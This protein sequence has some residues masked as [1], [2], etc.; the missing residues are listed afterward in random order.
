[1]LPVVWEHPA[2]GVAHDAAHDGNEHTELEVGDQ[3]DLA[4]EDGGDHDGAHDRDGVDAVLLLRLLLPPSLLLLG[5]QFGVG[6]HEDGLP[7][8]GSHVGAEPGGGL[9][10]GLGGE[11][12]GAGGGPPGPD[13]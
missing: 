10:P 12:H 6:W 1:M 4:P 8:A 5:G 7:A 3:A 9:A 11:S 2:G 13:L